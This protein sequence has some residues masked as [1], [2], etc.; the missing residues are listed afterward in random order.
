VEIRGVLFD[1]DGTLLDIDIDEFLSRYFPALVG[2][3]SQAVAPDIEVDRVA[4]ALKVATNAMTVPHGGTNRDA[5]NATMQEMTGVDL[6]LEPNAAAVERFYTE[7]FPTLQGNA[8]PRPDSRRAVEFALE[9]GMQVAIATHPLFPR[10]A[11]EQRLEWAGVGGLPVHHM[12]T[13]E[14]ATSTKPHGAYFAETARA[15][16]LA[17]AECIMVGDDAELD[18]PAAATGMRVFHITSDP[19]PD[20]S[21]HGDLD[22]VIHLLDR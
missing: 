14:V 16:G 11:I 18:I 17:P 9:R 12:T 13:Y 8:G 2:Y 1:L 21:W 22:G 19:H 5:F 15:L 3:M 7:V 6:W 10:A 4:Q 20:A